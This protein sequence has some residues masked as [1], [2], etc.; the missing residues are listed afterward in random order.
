MK[1]RLSI[2][3]GALFFSLLAFS[4]CG[5]GTKLAEGQYALVNNKIEIVGQ[6]RDLKKSDISHYIK[7]Q[8]P[9]FLSYGQKTVFEERL[10]G[11][12]EDKIREHLRYL[13]YYDAQVDSE[14]EL[15]NKKASPGFSLDIL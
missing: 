8:P 12:S 11:V 15:K 4:S 13:G 6:T 10:V 7:Q 14:V 3:S 5:A 1:S 9:S 2:L